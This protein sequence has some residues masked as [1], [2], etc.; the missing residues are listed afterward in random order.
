MNTVHIETLSFPFGAP[1]LNGN[2]ALFPDEKI[3][4]S[5]GMGTQVFDG[6]SCDLVVVEASGTIWN[7]FHIW[8]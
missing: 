7:K 4:Y 6:H 8:I 5:M 1:L 2:W 3:L